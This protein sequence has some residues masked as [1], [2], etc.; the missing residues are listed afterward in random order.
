M[1]LKE[2]DLVLDSVWQMRYLANKIKSD[3]DSLYHK[4]HKEMGIEC[5][6]RDP[7]FPCWTHTYLGKYY[8]TERQVVEALDA[9]FESI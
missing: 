9:I 7:G 2:Y 6:S 3:A 1:T 8:E 4:L 5:H